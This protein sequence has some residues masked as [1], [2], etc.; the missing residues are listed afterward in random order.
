MKSYYTLNSTIV[1]GIFIK[2][3]K[4]RFLCI[5]RINH[6]DVE[7]YIPCS[8]HLDH[9]IDLVGKKVLVTPNIQP[10]TR[11]AYSVLAVKYKR[12]NIILN[13]FIANKALYSFLMY[14]KT[15]FYQNDCII[16]SEKKI[17]NYKSDILI[18]WQ[19]KKEVIEVKS[20]ISVY[21]RATFPTIFS[22]RAI[23]QLEQFLQFPDNVT[24]QCCFISL[25][26]Y[27]E[28]LYI[29]KDQYQ[30]YD[31]FYKCLNQGMKCKAYTCS[32]VGNK[33]KITK[34][35]PIII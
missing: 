18:E 14:N 29:N 1:T 2:E 34:E 11:T 15:K 21:P 22:A 17:H 25:S 28:E 35:I 4:N 3:L 6:K 32:L 8:S 26:P 33:I 9:F 31:L 20:I 23:K 24:T 30:Y 10:G 13:T 12:R 5:V 7:C 27:I 16:S 19:A